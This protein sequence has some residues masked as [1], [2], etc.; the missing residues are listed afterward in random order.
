MSIGSTIKRLRREKDITQEQLAE[1]LGITSR[2]VSQWECDRTAPDISQLPAL[3]HIFD[4]SSDVLLGIDIEKNNE[5]IQRYLSKATELGHQSKREERTALL[6]EANKKFP[7]DYKIMQSLADSLVCEYSRKGTN[8]YEEVFELCNR[9]L[10][11][12][13]DSTTRYEAIE[14]LGTAYGYAGK[15][16][17][18]LKLAKE[19]PRAHFS[20]ENFMTYRWK[21]DADF[22]E[23]Q[24]YLSF[25]IYH[26]AEM[27][28]LATA[29]R[30]DNGDFIYS[31]EDRIRLW[32]TTIKFLELLFPDGDLQYKAQL[33]EIACS[34]LCTAYLGKQDYEEAWKW[35]EKGAYFAVHMDTYDF[36]APHTSPVLRGYSDGGWIMEAEGNRSRSMLDW[37]TKDENA[38]ALRSDARFEPLIKR[39]EKTA[40]KPLA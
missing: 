22:K 28:E 6:R 38:A 21:G 11:E 17:E 1:Y 31:L 26:T 39:L 23:F 36:D 25:L 40:K 34:F 35:L 5:E 16:D 7:R 9:I 27:I 12:C 18:M 14:T 3:C 24:D 2:A 15:K 33:G 30:H 10:S 37:L 13:T 8:D 32:E 19:M 4:V 29:Q 20:Y